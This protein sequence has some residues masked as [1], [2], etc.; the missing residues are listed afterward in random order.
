MTPINDTLQTRQTVSLSERNEDRL[1]W[2]LLE[3]RSQEMEDRRVLQSVYESL[4]HSKRP[5]NTRVAF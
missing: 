2:S 3:G 5:I 1:F 4:T